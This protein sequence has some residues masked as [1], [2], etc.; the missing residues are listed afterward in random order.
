MNSRRRH[1][2]WGLIPALAVSLECSQSP[3]D[4]YTSRQILA[5]ESGS[6]AADGLWEG[7]KETLRYHGF[8]LDRVDR[9]AGVITTMPVTSQQIFEFWRRDVVTWADRWEASLNPIR[10]WVEVCIQPIEGEFGQRLT[11]VVH[12]E[13]LSSP[14]RQF[15]S[16]GAVYRLFDEQVPAVTER[17]RDSVRKER[18][19]SLGRDAALENHLLNSVIQYCGLTGAAD[20]VPDLDNSESDS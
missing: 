7:V 2:C 8:P 3:S 14:D 11:F 19:L 10:R 12:K 15:T 5:I 18:W 20:T 1:V 17:R 6:E 13:R 16:S 9:R 4:S